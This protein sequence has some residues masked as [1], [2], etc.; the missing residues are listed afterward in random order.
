MYLMHLESLTPCQSV[1]TDVSSG[2]FSIQSSNEYTQLYTLWLFVMPDTYIIN[3]A[4]Y[5]I[6][7]D[8]DV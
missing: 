4:T 2:Q 1:V 3:K 8:R 6:K 5:V 7:P